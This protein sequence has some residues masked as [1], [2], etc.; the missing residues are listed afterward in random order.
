M[1]FVTCC[2]Q[3]GYEH[4]MYCSRLT[5]ASVTRVYKILL[6]L[7]K[8][9]SKVVIS[10][11]SKVYI[12]G[13]KRLPH[14]DLFRNFSRKLSSGMKDF[15]IGFRRTVGLNGYCCHPQNIGSS[16]YTLGCP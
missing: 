12:S 4:C 7:S 15:V 14:Y 16:F 3:F 1:S 13:T 8:W 9:S 5:L 11:V 2:V 10:V 6:F